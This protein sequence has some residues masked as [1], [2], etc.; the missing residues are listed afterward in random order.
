MIMSKNPDKSPG[1]LDAWLLRLTDY[2]YDTSEEPIKNKLQAAQLALGARCLS[3]LL[4][5]H[6]YQL[7]GVNAI[8]ATIE[9][10][11]KGGHFRLARIACDSLTSFINNHPTSKIDG[12]IFSTL[13]E[14]L[15]GYCP[16]EGGNIRSKC[17]RGL[18][19]RVE[20]LE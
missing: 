7:K 2:L 16:E 12:T 8:S 4:A 5:H 15:T 6:P 1:V 10:L 19:R 11:S 13:K 18:A 3:E 14:T 17:A 20:R 9:N